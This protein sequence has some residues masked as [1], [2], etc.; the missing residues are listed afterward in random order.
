M[1]SIRFGK[2]AISLPKSRAARVAIGSGFVLGG[3]LGFLPVLGFW[4]VPIGLVVLSHDFPRVRRL[5]RQSEVALMRRW[6]KLRKKTAPV[7]K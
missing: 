6:A 7:A 4:M 2:K 1:A 5:R 3:T